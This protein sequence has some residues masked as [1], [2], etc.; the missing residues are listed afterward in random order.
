[1]ADGITVTIIFDFRP[2]AAEGF[3]AGLPGMLEQTRAKPGC[4]AIKALRSDADRNRV[5][6][7]EEWDS[8]ADYQAYIAW[9]ES[10]GESLE[11]MQAALSGPP[12]FDIWSDRIA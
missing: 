3:I 4:R 9:R 6:F 11:A 1:M 7:L 5:I 12:H 2:E 10:R 8:L